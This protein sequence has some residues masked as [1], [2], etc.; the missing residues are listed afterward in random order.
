MT[1]LLISMSKSWIVGR[2]EYFQGVQSPRIARIDMQHGDRILQHVKA[3][4]RRLEP[5]R[6][7]LESRLELVTSAVPIAS[8]PCETC[9]CRMSTRISDSVDGACLCCDERDQAHPKALLERCCRY[10]CSIPV[11][12]PPATQCTKANTKNNTREKECP[13]LYRSPPTGLFKSS[14]DPKRSS[15]RAALD[16]TPQVTDIRHAHVPS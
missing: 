4:E 8:L 1:I 7:N 6:E 12:M 9:L 13:S 11:H 15:P 10:C 16:T 5:C 2:A 14:Q 3:P